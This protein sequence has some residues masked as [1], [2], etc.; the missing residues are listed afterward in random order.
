MVTAMHSAST[1][2]QDM[3]H[4]NT[5]QKN[6]MKQL[7]SLIIYIEAN[8]ARPWACCCWLFKWRW[9]VIQNLVKP[10]ISVNTF[11]FCVCV[12]VCVSGLVCWCHSGAY[13]TPTFVRL[14][15]IPDSGSSGWKK[16]EKKTKLADRFQ[17]L[18]CASPWLRLRGVHL[19]ILR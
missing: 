9:V 11:F 8:S 15:L 10:D 14:H 17:T 6:G 3:L 1:W 18:E 13:I 7:L 19:Q 12:C 5:G 2:G 4:Y 16:A